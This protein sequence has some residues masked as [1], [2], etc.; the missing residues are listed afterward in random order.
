MFPQSDPEPIED[1]K[2][3]GLLR[4]GQNDGEFKGSTNCRRA[5]PISAVAGYSLVETGKQKQVNGNLGLQ[6]GQGKNVK[7]DVT[8]VRPDDLQYK[9]DADIQTPIEN[10]KKTTLS[11]HSKRSAD[12]SHITSNV[13]AT[14][15]GKTYHVDTEL[16]SSDISPLFN[17]KVKN[18]EGQVSQL[19]LKGN[20]VGDKEFG[21]EIK[22][23]CDANS[24]LLEAN[25][26][27]SVESV[28]E[29]V[30]K[31]NVNCPK[32]NLNKIAFEAVNKPGKTGRKIQVNV[33]SAG[34]NLVSGSTNYHSREENGKYVV[35][36]S[37]NFKVKEESKAANFKYICQRLSKDKD[38]EQ[39]LEISFDGSLGNRAIDAEFKTTDKQIRNM[40]TYCEKTKE[41]AQIELDSKI[42][43]NGKILVNNFL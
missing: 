42:N 17:F 24:F 3:E 15:D 7:I 5:G 18:S 20:R 41:C 1:F 37:G 6:Y 30:I 13:V 11:V 12:N 39:G 28:E 14:T 27:A 25:L 10:F 19:Y 32:L 16:K 22:A 34:K 33:K 31:G 26:D 9:F 2:G 38:G 8:L 4:I 40:I 21:G 36:G 43:R 29:F 35:E 23:I